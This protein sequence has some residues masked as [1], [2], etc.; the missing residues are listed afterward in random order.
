MLFRSTGSAD[1]P[2]TA[3]SF[4]AFWEVYPRKEARGKAEPAYRRALKRAS[5]AQILVGARRYRDDPNREQQ[6]TKIPTSWLNSDGWGDDP[7]PARTGTAVKRTTD[8]KVRDG[9]E[10]ARRL[11]AQEASQQLLIEGV[12]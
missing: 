11:A 1:G 4:A 8:D 12:A 3:T 7:L 9:I 6:Y 10:L 2:S 5:A